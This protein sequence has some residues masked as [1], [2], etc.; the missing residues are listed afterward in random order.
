LE[1]PLT[2]CPSDMSV[3]RWYVDGSH[4][5]LIQTV[6]GK[7][8]D[9]SALEVEHPSP[10]PSSK[11][12]TLAVRLNWSLLLLMMLLPPFCGLS[13]FWR[14]RAVPLESVSSTRTTRVQFSLRRMDRNPLPNGPST[15]TAV[16]SLSLIRSRRATCLLNIVQP[17][18]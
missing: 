3:L 13:C 10:L 18:R 9:V 11:I 2:I 15:S 12:S 16:I 1:L 7:P 14:H 17:P 4:T 5:R 6:M 8:V